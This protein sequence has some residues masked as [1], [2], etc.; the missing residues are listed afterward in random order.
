MCR[1]HAMEMSAPRRIAPKFVLTSAVGCTVI[2]GKGSRAYRD[3]EQSRSTRERGFE[4]YMCTP[5]A[6]E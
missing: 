2:A 4:R 6:L 1:T 5:G 3:N